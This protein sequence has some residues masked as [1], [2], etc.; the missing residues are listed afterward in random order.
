MAEKRVYEVVFIID[1]DTAEEDAKRLVESLQQIA[2]DQGGNVTKN[3]LMGRRPLAYRIGRKTEGVYILFE[4]EGTGKEIA[5]LERRMRV[6][7]QVLRYL[8][9]RV[10]ED[11]QRAEKFKEKRARRASKR[12]FAAGAGAGAGGAS[13][14]A[15][16]ATAGGDE[17]D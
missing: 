14:G 8:T 10:D 4:I 2:I 1:P 7:D 6:N 16:G 12:G 5:E 3:E 17:E 15:G 13:R 9:V 11:R